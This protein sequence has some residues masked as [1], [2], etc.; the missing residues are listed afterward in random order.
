MRDDLF[1]AM[2][3]H[4]VELAKEMENTEL[5]SFG[6]ASAHQQMGDVFRNLG[7]A[8]EAL[9]Q[10]QQAH[11]LVK[12]GADAKPDDDRGR[13]N[14]AVMRLRLGDM[15]I[16]LRGDV[17][18]TIGHYQNAL[19]LQ[20]DVEDHPRNHFYKPND[21]RR[22]Q[23]GYLF[24]LGETSKLMGDPAAARKYFTECSALH[25]AW[26]QD[27]GQSLPAQ[28]YL[29]EAS[30][31]L[32]DACWRLDDRAAMH[33]A[34]KEG[35]ALVETTL[36]RSPHYDFKADLAEALLLYADACTRLG[37][38]EQAAKLC[39]KCP[40]LVRAALDAEPQNLRYLGLM[41]R[42][43]YTQGVLAR[44]P[45][46]AAAPFADALQW[47]EKLAALDPESVPQQAA[48][49]ACLARNGN[50]A[51][52]AAKAEALRPRVAKNPDLLVQLAGGYALCAIA[53]ADRDRQ[54]YTDQ[55]LGVLRAVR[56]AGY[57]DSVNLRTHP[58][59]GAIADAPAF[60]E[61]LAQVGPKRN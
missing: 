40:P 20:K 26:L 55:A 4:L 54:R 3:K 60:K 24:K 53:S 21:H 13:A 37:E 23:G 47:R 59:L 58:D 18:R 27:D 46:D 38:Q 19:K 42:T 9:A 7:M 50:P 51:A 52:A 17:P 43:S 48:L 5:T 31:W 16:A 33:A 45:Q 29:A 35:I 57:K 12:K 61:L 1:Q 56:D 25:R 22:L 28:S 49:V 6:L 34:F 15:E 8:T 10:F 36:E 39:A 14:T 41:A 11:D 2:R 32:G 44:R 30:L